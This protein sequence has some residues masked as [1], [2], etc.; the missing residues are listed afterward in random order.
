MQTFEQ[1]V[2][3]IY[4]ELHPLAESAL[5]DLLHRSGHSSTG[6]PTLAHSLTIRNIGRA[7]GKCS[8]DGGVI[9]NAQLIDFPGEVRDTVAHELAH[10]VVETARRQRVSSWSMRTVTQRRRSGEWAAHGEIWKWVARRLGDSGD[11]C[12]QLPLKPV[13]RLRRYRYRAD[14]GTEIVLSSVRHKRLQR[15]PLFAYTAPRNGAVFLARHCV[16]EVEDG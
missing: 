9:V 14:C 16:G 3:R 2:R 5:H 15:N 7:A 10:A 4:E 1:T 13:R 6:S 11:R 12:H 8:P